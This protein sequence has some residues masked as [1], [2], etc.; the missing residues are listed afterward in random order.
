GPNA[1]L[2][3]AREG[4]SW[5]DV[6]LK[7]CW[8]SFTYKGFWPL[9]KRFWRSGFNEFQQSLRKSEYLKRVQ[10]YC[11]QIQLE[12]LQPYRHG[13]RAQAVTDSGDLLHDFRFVQTHNSLHVGNAP[14]PA[15]TS[16]IPIA[17]AVVDKLL[18]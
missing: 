1:V 14:S 11:P 7:D 10:K 16:A 6:N 12:D 2:A 3:L 8:D 18:G 15:A 9:A 13:V 17:K 5:S 4:Y